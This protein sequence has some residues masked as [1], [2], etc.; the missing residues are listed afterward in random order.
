MLIVIPARAGSQ[1]IPNKAL[2]RLGQHP[3]LAY[4]IASAQAA[5]R[6]VVAS[7]DDTILACARHYGAETW[8]RPLHTATDDAPD[9]TWLT[10]FVDSGRVGPA[11][12]FVLRRLTS[13]FITADTITR[14][15]NDFL[16]RAGGDGDARDAGGDR[17]SAEDVGATGT[18][19]VPA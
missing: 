11:E 15:F 4:T 16:M 17:T 6:A 9:L 14:A 3:L 7:E 12:T 18:W 5:G 2:R 8:L 1:R 13:P 10:L 19:V